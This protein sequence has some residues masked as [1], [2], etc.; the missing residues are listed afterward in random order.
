MTTGDTVS[1]LLVDGQ[2]LFRDALKEMLGAE[3]DLSVVGDTGDSRAALSLAADTQPDVVLLDS[4]LTEHDPDLIRE[5][6]ETT[7]L[8]RVLVLAPTDDP[9]L[10]RTLLA[11]GIRGYLLKNVTRNELVSAIR[12]V[13]A[14]GDRIVLVV[15]RDALVHI[16]RSAADGISRREREI[17][18]LV[19]EGLSNAQIA[20]RLSIADGTV[21]RH[22]GNIFTKLRAVSRVDAVNKAVAA[23]VIPAF[24]PGGRPSDVRA[25]GH[26][27]H[28]DSERFLA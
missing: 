22:L 16:G 4:T 23:S 9:W 1:V 18:L 27:V 25:N 13:C 20:A 24:Q 2:V 28:S 19:S 21:K 26:P 10:I 17:L 14:Q 3:P 12:S 5:L 15:S 11:Q 7:P 8:S 6:L